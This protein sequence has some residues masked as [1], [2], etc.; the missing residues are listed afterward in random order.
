MAQFTKYRYRFDAAGWAKPGFPLF[1]DDRGGVCSKSGVTD[2]I[3]KAARHLGQE[4]VDPGGLFLHSGHAMRVTGAQG[5]AR[6]GLTEHNIALLARWG[7][8]S[9]LTYIRKAPLA[10]SHHMAAAALA[11][12]DRNSAASSSTALLSRSSAAPAAQLPRTEARRPEGP[13][14]ASHAELVGEV[15][16]LDRRVKAT[17][18]QLR[19][20]AELRRNVAKAA[21]PDQISPAS[22]T[23]DDVPAHWASVVCWFPFVSSTRAKVHRVVVGYPENPRH[24]RSEC[25]WQFGISEVAHPVLRLPECHKAM[26]DRCFK[27]E[28]E[29][30][31]AV[32]EQRVREVG[33][34]AE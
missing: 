29:A 18:D 12:W 8:A 26:C 28:K 20:L 34:D 17:E 13:S 32:A 30:A 11:G 33:V 23:V 1:P 4:L 19:E 27:A 7:K 16:A 25:G 24:W 10:A 14:T 21:P 6:A 15:R 3:R 9:V 2:T 5:L 22:V 31:K